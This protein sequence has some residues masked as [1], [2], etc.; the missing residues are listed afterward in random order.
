MDAFLFTDFF[1]RGDCAILGDVPYL[2]DGCDKDKSMEPLVLFIYSSQ[3][4]SS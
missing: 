3:V 2:G 4:G 1:I